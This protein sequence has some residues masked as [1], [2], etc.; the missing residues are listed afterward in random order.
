MIN[1]L[2]L[3]ISNSFDPYEN[4]A[5][6]KYLFDKTPE[7]CCTLYLWQNHR[8]VVIGRNQNPWTECKCSLLES[9]GGKLARRLSGGGTVF[10]DLGN[11][12]FT[13]LCSTQNYD[14]AKQMLVIQKAC[15]LA[16][17]DAEISGRNDILADGKKFSG[18]AFYNSKG[19]SY[20]H[21]TLLINADIPNMQRY[22]TPPKAK[23]EAKGIKSVKSRVV[24][25]SELSPVLS[26]Q[27]MTDY[28][29]SAFEDI[30]G[31][32]A[33]FWKSINPDKII[34][35]AK[36]Y[37]SWEYL[38]GTL[39]PFSFTCEGHFSWGHIELNMQIS[40]GIIKYV[41]V[42]TDTLEWNLP[43]IIN[44]AL[45]ECR[46]EIPIMSAALTNALPHKLAEDIVSLLKNQEL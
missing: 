26:C 29:I 20:H 38:Y 8:T 28:M 5:I 18:N 11:L 37:G 21:G 13:F 12:N 24:N 2:R 40:N 35:L 36:H 42:Y 25:L 41:K 32:K 17:V 27:A 15:T 33:I 22:L 9:E 34:P 10:H 19:K 46:F 43:E 23:L 31:M 44:T 4:L 1:Q 3:Y 16:E 30:Y 45:F 14:L 7:D 39:P 6:E